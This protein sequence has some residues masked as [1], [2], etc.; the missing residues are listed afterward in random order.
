VS[1]LAALA[2]RGWAF[3]VPGTLTFDQV[4]RARVFAWH[5][6]HYLYANDTLLRVL[7]HYPNTDDE[8]GPL[9]GMVVRLS[10]LRGTEHLLDAGW[11]HLDDCSCPFCSPGHNEAGRGHRSRNGCHDS[12][13]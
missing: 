8:A 3:S 9:P 10:S 2:A 7:A 1:K 6:R 12:G 5:E 4:K 13:G 11:H